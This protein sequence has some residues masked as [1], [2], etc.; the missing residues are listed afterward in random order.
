MLGIYYH[1]GKG[2]GFISSKG[3]WIKQENVIMKS[4]SSY[5]SHLLVLWYLPQML[6]FRQKQKLFVLYFC[7]LEKK[8]FLSSSLKDTFFSFPSLTFFLVICLS[9]YIF[10]V[11]FRNSKVKVYLC[12]CLNVCC[13]FMD[14]LPLLLFDLERYTVE[15]RSIF[16]M[17]TGA[18]FLH[19]IYSTSTNHKKKY[20][21]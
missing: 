9:I 14:D 6:S 15:S 10:F 4:L 1:L 2:Y 13:C 16:R 21:K 7:V 5:L 19:I 17:L 3:I 20:V 8:T 11:C 12:F 18:V